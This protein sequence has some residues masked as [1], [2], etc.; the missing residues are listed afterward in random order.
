MV[1]ASKIKQIFHGELLRYIAAICD[2]RRIDSNRRKMIVLG[3]L[4]YSNGI[5]FE[6]LGGATN[7]IALQID[8]YAVKFAMDEQ[9]YKDNWVEYALSPELQPVV[10]KSYET[11]GYILIAECVEVMTEEKFVLYKNE[12]LKILDRL[13]NDY[14]LGDVGY[15][16]KN[17]TNWG[18]R[19]NTPVILD[20]AYCH[21]ATEGLFTCSQCGSILTYDSV[22]DILMCTNRVDGCK[23]RYTYNDRK[24]IQG[25]EVDL[26]MIQDRKNESVKL[27]AGEE[28]KEI[29]LFEDRL[30]GDNYFVIDNPGDM[31]RYNK[32]KEEIK[33]NLY[34]N[35]GENENMMENSLE[36]MVD[37]IQKKDVDNAKKVLFQNDTEPEIPEP[38]YTDGYRENYLGGHGPAIRVY[39][40]LSVDEEDDDDSDVGEQ[41]DSRS[42]D[43]EAGLEALIDAQMR[44]RDAEAEKLAQQQRDY[45][46][47]NAAVLNAYLDQKEQESQKEKKPVPEVTVTVQKE[48]IHEERRGEDPV[49]EELMEEQFEETTNGTDGEAEADEIDYEQQEGR[50][51]LVPTPDE[52]PEGQNIAILDRETNLLY[53]VDGKVVVFETPEE[54]SN[55]LD[56]LYKSLPVDSIEGKSTTGEENTGA[57]ND[58]AEE[59]HGESHQEEESGGA[60]EEEEE[61]KTEEASILVDGKPLQIG[62]EVKISV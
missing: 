61:T 37:I 7:R 57:T 32:L 13:C 33:M 53:E 8:G 54:A 5:N 44:K 22:Y 31:N 26:G 48:E 39:A 15:L 55:Y 49:K 25:D 23:A 6:I 52:F 29:E 59:I 60:V 47:A 10:T 45:D 42:F 56:E 11:N 40:G 1:I 24:R 41:L 20:Y 19:G 17:M 38:V 28:S 4:L 36:A 34:L 35:G 58:A 62:Q 18:L 16:K 12:I 51:I 3:N 27:G 46:D 14:L 2:T 43:M 30:L 50:F 21:R 9:G